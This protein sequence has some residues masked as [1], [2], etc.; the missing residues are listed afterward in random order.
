[1]AGISRAI[2]PTA[3]CGYRS[4]SATV[5]RFDAEMKVAS[6]DPIVP[7]GMFDATAPE[8]AWLLCVVALLVAAAP[9]VSVQ[10]ADPV[11][12]DG[13]GVHGVHAAQAAS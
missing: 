12:R 6:C 10:L 9:L 2:W 3:L 7:G 4:L 8:A 5:E 11:G 13:R 1:V